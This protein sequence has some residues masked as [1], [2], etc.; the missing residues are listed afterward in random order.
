MRLGVGLAWTWASWRT[1]CRSIPISPPKPPRILSHLQGS[2]LGP[3]LQED[4]P[5][6][7]P[8]HQSLLLRS[9]AQSPASPGLSL[10]PEEV[11]GQAERS[12]G[13]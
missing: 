2:T 11:Q 5:D 10:G 13:W 1:V 8:N 3:P 9:V 7:E 6:P 12:Q 4:P